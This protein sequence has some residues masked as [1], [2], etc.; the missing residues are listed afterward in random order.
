[1]QAIVRVSAYHDHI[2]RC[3][4]SKIAIDI[5]VDERLIAAARQDN[6]EMLLEIFDQGGYD[7]NFQDG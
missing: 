6:E 7:I 2:T 4:C 1:M 3:I 5:I